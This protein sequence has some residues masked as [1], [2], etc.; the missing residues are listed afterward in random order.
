MAFRNAFQKSY[1]YLIADNKS[2]FML[3]GA[4]P[5]DDEK[6]LL[7]HGA[8]GL[9]TQ[10]LIRGI[11]RKH[12]GNPYL[13]QELDAA[14][15]EVSSRKIAFTTD[16]FVVSPIFF[17]G[18]DIG[19][20]A[21][22]G[23]VNDL[24]V[25]GAKPLYLTLGLIIEEGLP[26]ETLDRL[27]YSM[28]QTAHQA[29][30]QIV[31]GDTKVV[32]HGACDQ[33]YINTSGVGAVPPDLDL[34]PRRMAPGDKVIVSGPVGNHGIAILA[35]RE[36]LKFSPPPASD[37]TYLSDLIDRV[38]STGAGIKCMRDP[39]RGGL[40]TTLVELAG[41]SGLGIKLFEEDVPVDPQVKG[42]CSMLG[43]DPLYMANEGKIVF[44]VESKDAPAVVHEIQKHEAGRGAGIIGEVVGDHPGKVV[45]E[46]GL[47]TLRALHM[48]EGDPLPRIC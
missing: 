32:E 34:S 41:Q 5:L 11:F 36:G 28:G 22:C 14:L 8:G 24:A 2:F 19:K 39:T 15:I 10:R 3:W 43:L 1:H 12:L 29:K 38:V 20:L 35:A 31:A 48:L 21:V 40:A 42:A 23:T 27:V 25:M 13:Q 18:G 26:M 47:G 6:I 46:T 7:S 17:P 4:K 33:I 45:M 44:V 37:C 9:K 30:V 16:S